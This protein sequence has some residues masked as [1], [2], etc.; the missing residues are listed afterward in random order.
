MSN[1]VLG[2]FRGLLYPVIGAILYVLAQTI[3]TSPVIAAPVALL[4]T[5]F[6]GYIEHKYNI[7]TPVAATPSTPPQQ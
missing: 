6:I 3:S 2:F 7:P 5:G 4:L 1:Q